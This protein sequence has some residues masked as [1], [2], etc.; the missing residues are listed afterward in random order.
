MTESAQNNYNQTLKKAEP[1]SSKTPEI[2]PPVLFQGILITE[3]DERDYL[4]QVLQKYGM[5]DKLDVLNYI[6]NAESSWRWWA[7]NDKSAGLLAFTKGTWEGDGGKYLGECRRFGKY[8]LNPMR[9]IDCA[10][11]LM[12]KGE[13]WRWDVFCTKWWDNEC[14]KRRG[15]HP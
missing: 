10:I 5:I 6:I 1:I 12:N 13:W 2:P 9:Q 11:M 14:I 7:F 3:Q 4:E 8:D 15:L